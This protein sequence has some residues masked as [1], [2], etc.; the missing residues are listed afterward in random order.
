MERRARIN[1]L[2]AKTNIFQLH[3]SSAHSYTIG[4]EGDISNICQFQFYE[5][6]YYYDSTDEFP[7]HRL[8]LGKVMGPSV[9]VG[10][11]IAQCILRGNGRVVSQRSARPLRT[12]EI[13]NNNEEKKWKVFDKLI[14]LRWGSSLN[15]PMNF[16][17]NKEQEF[18]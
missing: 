10:N 9:G 14:E 3:G 11:E 1:N 6:C 17:K 16:T 15:F 13:Y 4:E 18:E 8:V 5:W 7:H 12:D 2:T